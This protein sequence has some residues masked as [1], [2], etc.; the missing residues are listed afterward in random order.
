[1]L[2]EIAPA[3]EANSAIAGFSVASVA[4]SLCLAPGLKLD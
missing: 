4:R 1:M 2:A 3:K